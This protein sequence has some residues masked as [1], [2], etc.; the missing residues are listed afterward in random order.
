LILHLRPEEI[1]EN[2]KDKNEMLEETIMSGKDNE[3]RDYSLR[4]KQIL[5]SF[6]KGALDS[7]VTF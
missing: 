7:R 2:P 1:E 5:V 6:V 3:K 4:W